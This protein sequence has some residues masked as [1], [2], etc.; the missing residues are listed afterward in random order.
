MFNNGAMKSHFSSASGV[1]RCRSLP[2]FNDLKVIQQDV[3]RLFGAFTEVLVVKDLR[4]KI[5]TI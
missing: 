4:H 1:T 5:L 3:P 2:S